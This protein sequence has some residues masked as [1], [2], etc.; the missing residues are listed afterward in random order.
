MRIV[1]R[2]I[3]REM[4]SSLA[5]GLLLFT[6][7]LF[8]GRLLKLM[9]L[10][11]TRG[12]PAGM[13]LTLFLYLLP[14]FLV[15][16]VPMAV[17]LG[18]LSAY[19]RLA[20]DNE[21]LALRTA[22][23]SLYR[24]IVPALLLGMAAA[25]AGAYLSLVALPWGTQGFRDLLFRLSRTKATLALTEGLF[26]AELNG[27]ILYVQEVD[28]ETG[29]LRGIF[30]ADAQDPR[31]PRETLAARG[32]LKGEGEAG[33]VTLALEEGSLHSRLAADPARYRL[34]TFRRYEMRLELAAP[35]A[36]ADRERSPRE[37]TLTELTQAIRKA[38]ES[39]RSAAAFTFQV[40]QRFANLAA[41]LVFVLVG[42]PLGIQVRRSGRGASLALSV[43][44]ALA[45]YLLM[46]AGEG[47]ATQ[48]RVP[49][50]VGAWLPNGVVGA[51]GLVLL[52]L[53]GQEG[54]LESLIPWR[55]HAHP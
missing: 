49:A 12:V 52:L 25:A 3:L 46:V 26:S 48:G 15:I 31:H 51:L 42:A 4:V 11:V 35:G 40:H 44:V 9:E 47:L 39:G 23:W 45:Y 37:L 21:V 43:L 2:Y 27:L 22:G 50:A 14:S 6:L 8:A 16:T 1:D 53:G 55:G 30:V 10:I 41:A 38:E 28:D 19:G 24:L 54:R 34:V 7:V 17:L 5:L 20:A 18:T 36:G 29:E 33:G 32:R 13:V